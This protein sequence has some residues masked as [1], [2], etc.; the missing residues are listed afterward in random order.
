MEKSWDIKWFAAYRHRCMA[1]STEEGKKYILVLI[2]YTYLL[3]DSNEN[4]LLSIFVRLLN[5][6]Y[7]NRFI[8]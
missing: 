3:Q 7:T 1:Y 5:T 4:I 6:K 2:Y 8:L